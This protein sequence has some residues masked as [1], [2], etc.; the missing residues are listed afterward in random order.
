LP[1]SAELG[2]I[3]L[4]LGKGVT[5][6]VAKYKAVVA[7]TQNAFA[8]P[9]FKLFH[10]LAE[11]TYHALLSVP[12]VSGGETMGVLNAHHREPH[13]HSPE[14]VAL[15]S[16]LGEQMGS[17]I[18]MSRL[19]DEN[20]RLNE[21][22]TEIQQQLES[23]KVLERAKGIMQQRYKMSEEDA[24]LRLRNESRRSRRPI[25]EVA[26]VVLMVEELAV[27]VNSGNTRDLI[28]PPCTD[29]WKQTTWHSTNSDVS[30]SV[31]R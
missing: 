21:K 2:R 27:G 4:K 14:E 13:V 16:F 17:V 28:G 6:W 5:G 23:R 7:L 11:D 10:S 18:A 3:R 31:V 29:R 19:A 22:A 25:R 24:Y 9:R 20:A 8:D 26:E 1:H 15:L 30:Y 12:L